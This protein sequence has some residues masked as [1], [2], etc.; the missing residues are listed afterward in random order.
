MESIRLASRGLLFL[1]VTSAL[2]SIEQR[3]VE[4]DG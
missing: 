4:T 3:W 1:V 2:V